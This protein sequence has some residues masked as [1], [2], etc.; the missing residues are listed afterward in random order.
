M[1]SISISGLIFIKGTGVPNRC[2]VEAR[3]V[4]GLSV[5]ASLFIYQSFV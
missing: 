2:Y 3:G 5:S 1:P 4:G